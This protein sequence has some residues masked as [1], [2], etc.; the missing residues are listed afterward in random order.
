MEANKLVESKSSIGDILLFKKRLEY[1]ED[2]GWDTT[3]F[4]VNLTKEQIKEL[5]C[6]KINQ[7][8]Q[9]I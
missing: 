6:L 9:L 4:P 5:E 3:L 7:T 8:L 1:A 2:K